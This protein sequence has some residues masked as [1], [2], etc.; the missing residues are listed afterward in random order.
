MSN[1]KLVL[2]LLQW[3]GKKRIYFIFS[4]LAAFI[5]G[6]C[7]MIPYYSIYKLIEATYSS[8]LDSQVLIK[9]GTYVI[10]GIPAR[11]ILFATSGMLSHKGA[12]NTLYDVR[13]MVINHMAKIP[14]GRLNEKDTGE[15]KS[16]INEEIEKLEVFLAHSL[17]EVVFYICGPI[18]IFVYF[19][20]INFKLALVS[21]LPLII[22][23]FLMGIMFRN[24]DDMM[25]RMYRSIAKLNSAMV[26]YINGMR[27]IKAYKMGSKSFKKYRDAVN[28]EN[29]MWNEVSRKMSPPYAA[30]VVIIEAGMLFMIPI[31]GYMFVKGTITASVLILFVFVG[32]FYLTEIRPLQELGSKFAEVIGA[33]KKAK[34]IIDIESFDSTGEFPEDTTIEMKNVAFSYRGTDNVLTDCSL[35]I[36]SGEKIALVGPSGAGKSTVIQLI[37]R[38]YDVTDGEILIGGRNIKEINYEELL[39]NISIV[40]QKT[41]LS[42]SS[43]LDNI[44]MGSNATPDEVRNAAK[45]AQIDDFIKGLPKGYQTKIG[46]FSARLSGGEKQRIAIA[47]AI[48]KDAPILILDEATSA[49]DPENQYEIDQ[50]ITNLCR[51]KTVI[52]VAHRLGIVKQCDKVAVVESGSISQAYPHEELLAKSEYYRNAW[53]DYKEARMISY[54]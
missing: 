26:E 42:Q 13:C 45:Q 43:I 21:I 10:V 46:T 3:S 6:L 34:D 54:D 53:N 50:A 17:P 28:E 27:V 18:T 16:V 11:F 14:L 35:K 33:V 12:F 37:S 30:Y 20:T 5:S 32:S 19:C 36:K 49:A 48:L 39:K 23:I 51:G 31:A 25:E 40:F 8:N 38:F 7:V 9:Y 4:V 1:K 29:D 2:Q 44:K 52:I 47:R 41:F 22:A 24:T 15:I